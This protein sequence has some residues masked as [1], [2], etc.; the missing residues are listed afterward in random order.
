[1]LRASLTG[2]GSGGIASGEFELA[3][4]SAIRESGWFC[5]AN[6]VHTIGQTVNDTQRSQRLTLD[7][8][9]I[10]DFYRRMS[11]I[12]CSNLPVSGRIVNLLCQ[13]RA[14]LAKFLLRALLAKFGS[15]QSQ[16]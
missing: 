13:L 15:V 10:N 12:G 8:K 7:V 9:D 4:S 2:V 3:I 1:R 11:R 6:E 14:L 16:L 5:C